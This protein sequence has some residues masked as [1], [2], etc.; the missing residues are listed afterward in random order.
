MHLPLE[1]LG[2][3]SPAGDGEEDPTLITARDVGLLEQT[4]RDDPA[5]MTVASSP[6]EGAPGNMPR[7]VEGSVSSGS[8]AGACMSSDGCDGGREPLDD[9]PS[10]PGAAQPAF[11]S[12]DCV[13]QAD[14]SQEP[15]GALAVSCSERPGKTMCARKTPERE[16]TLPNGIQ[17]AL[18][19]VRRAMKGPRK[20]Q[21][22]GFHAVLLICVNGCHLYLRLLRQTFKT[23][24]VSL[25]ILQAPLFTRDFAWA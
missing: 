15:G 21:V 14:G 25:S 9:W 8:T 19:I 20:P 24:F 16:A 6:V 12:D 22:S 11:D 18:I 10:L 13:G 3:Q 5:E 7:S 17:S 1:F 23:P 2:G 4:P